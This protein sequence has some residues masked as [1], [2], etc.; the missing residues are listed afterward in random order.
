VG[1]KRKGVQGE[2]LANM[3]NDLIAMESTPI[4]RSH[5]ILMGYRQPGTIIMCKLFI[6]C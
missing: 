1:K 2:K 6:Y 5:E 4:S 3:A